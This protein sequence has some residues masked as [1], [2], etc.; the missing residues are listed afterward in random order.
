VGSESRTY[1]AYALAGAQHFD[2]SIKDKIPGVWRLLL[3]WQK[4]EIPVRAPPFVPNGIMAF[5]WIAHQNSR[6]DFALAIMIMFHA[7]LKP[8]DAVN[9]A[10]TIR[11]LGEFLVRRFPVLALKSIRTDSALLHA[12]QLGVF[13]SVH[14]V[15]YLSHTFLD[16]ALLLSCALCTVSF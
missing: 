5:A 7:F 10:N 13:C 6:R 2:P 11:L 14:C 8:V 16:N 15:H 4:H 3:A 12:W 9:S 1:G